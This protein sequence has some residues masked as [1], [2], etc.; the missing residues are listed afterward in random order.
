MTVTASERNRALFLGSMGGGLE[1]YDFVIYAS[2]ASQIGKTFFP[3]EAAATRLL[4]AFAVFAAGYLVRPIGG[5]LFSHF[6]D[7]YGRKLMLRVSI[8]GMA[9]ATFLIAFMPGYAS[10]GISATIALVALRMVQGLCLGGEIPGAMTL[11]TETMPKRRGLACGFLFMIINVGM[12][13]A[14]AVQWAIELLLSDAAVLSYGWRIGFFIGGLVAIAGFVLRARLSESPAFAELEAAT[15]KVPLAALF[16]DHRRAVWIGLF[17]TGL[18]AATV[19]LLYLYMNSYLTD[20]LKYDPDQVSTAVLVGIILFSLPMPLA[21]LI[22]DFVGI[23]VPAFI[24]ALALAIAA[25][26]VY[27]WIHQGVGELMPAMIVISLIGAFAWG[28]GPVLLTAIFPTDV[29]YSGVAFVYN[30]GFALV[31]GLTPLAATF[32]IQQTGFTLAPG[33]LLALFAAL[34]TVAIFLSQTLPAEDA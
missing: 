27:V 11:I 34:A 29:R 15:H 8:A 32:I 20:F 18:G 26:P 25:I 28:L 19:P 4:A 6:G 13:A 22:S 30:I 23:K 5:I 1:F 9:G 12:L 24:A 10:W 2:F 3:S 7:R 21:G 14:Q 33:F 31:G 16:R 17:V